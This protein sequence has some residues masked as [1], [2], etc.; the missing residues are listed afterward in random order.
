MDN[1]GYENTL[2]FPHNYT[3]APIESLLLHPLLAF[4]HPLGLIPTIEIVL[5]LY[6]LHCPC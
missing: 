3:K 2:L 4:D 6:W 1:K 5:S